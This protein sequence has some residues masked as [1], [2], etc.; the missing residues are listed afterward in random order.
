MSSR[1]SHSHSSHKHSRQYKQHKEYKDIE[2]ILPTAESSSRPTYQP[3]THDNDTKEIIIGGGG[4]QSKLGP[5]DGCGMSNAGLRA[6]TNEHLCQSCR[7]DMHYKLI[8]KS[9]AL[10]TYTAVDFTDLIEGFKSRQLQCFFIK[11]WHDPQAKPIKL[12]YEKEIRQLNEAKRR[13]RS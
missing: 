9:T 1:S 7:N 12:Y 5:C 6:I 10:T 13:Q 11:N 2:I 4:H 3:R 8:T